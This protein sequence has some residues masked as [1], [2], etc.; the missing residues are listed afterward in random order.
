VVLVRRV[1]TIQVGLKAP[2]GF[3]W[4]ANVIPRQAGAVADVVEHCSATGA[5]PVPPGRSLFLVVDRNGLT[6][7]AR[8]GGP[9]RKRSPGPLSALDLENLANRAFVE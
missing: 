5:G 4:F 9:V 2:G 7:D 3:A 8:V 6:V 1:G